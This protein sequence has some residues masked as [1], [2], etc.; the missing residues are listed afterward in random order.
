MSNENKTLLSY[1][2]RVFQLR[3]ERKHDLTLKELKVVARELGLTDKDFDAAESKAQEH[4]DLARTYG[5]SGR[6]AEAAKELRASLTL[7]PL[8]SETTSELASQLFALS[9]KEGS[10]THQNEA[11][12]IARACLR[13]N[14]HNTQAL[15]VL[16]AIDEVKKRKRGRL[17]LVLGIAALLAF[18][19]AIIIWS[20]LEPTNAEQEA[21][22]RS[23][24]EGS[25]ARTT[26]DNV[27]PT[28]KTLPQIQEEAPDVAPLKVIY[29]APPF[30]SYKAHSAKVRNHKER[31]FAE[32]FGLIKNDGD[33]I[34]TKIRVNT[35]LLDLSGGQLHVQERAVLSSLDPPLRPGDTLNVRW[36]KQ[37]DARATT[38][39]VE[40]TETEKRLAP[41]SYPPSELVP[42]EW[43]VSKLKGASVEARQREERS[44][45]RHGEGGFFHH[46]VF[47]VTYTGP[48]PLSELRFEMR[49]LNQRNELLNARTVVAASSMEGPMLSGETRVLR[50]IMSVP[51][52][53]GSYQLLVTSAQ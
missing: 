28:A 29:K 14:P 43:T 25:S 23:Q 5:T 53:V 12:L 26:P 45:P 41:E 16:T 19:A 17:P 1:I 20:N 10:S 8:H 33:A 22:S 50:S 6:H 13:K 35:Q 32:A 48:L 24:P 39:L 21:G 51:E 7:R 52:E 40:V 15:T 42:L 4:L 47:E 37:T 11:E 2:E 36:L 3:E 44:N 31:S 30:L 49:R 34:I 9:Q 18:G 38:L 27:L 46:A